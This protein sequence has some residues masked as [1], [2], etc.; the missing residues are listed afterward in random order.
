MR[1]DAAEAVQQLG[2]RPGERVLAELHAAVVVEREQN[3]NEPARH[4]HHATGVPPG[5]QRLL[6]H[7]GTKLAETH[8]GYRPG[9]PAF[10][11][12]RGREE[13][14]GRKTPPMMSVSRPRISSLP[15]PRCA[16]CPAFTPLC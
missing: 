9:T 4:A 14:R 5:L 10:G 3:L 7:R 6:Q 11:R 8:R 12:R 15:L 2:P 16:R 1:G 13:I